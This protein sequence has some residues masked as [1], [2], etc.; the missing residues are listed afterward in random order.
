MQE[1]AYRLSSRPMPSVFLRLG[2][3][4]VLGLA[5]CQGHSDPPPAAAP[6]NSQRPARPEPPPLAPQPLGRSGYTVALP[7]DY[8]LKPTDGP[9]FQVYYFAPADTL[10]AHHFTGGLYF[11]SQPQGPDS[12][13]GCQVRQQPATLLGRPATWH[14]TRCAS[15]YAVYAVF[16]SRSGR[17][18]D[19]QINAFGEARSAAELRQLLAVFATLRRE[20]GQ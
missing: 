9:D 17:G 6:P 15:G 10:A 7:A 3:A 16:D 19:A 12:T 14:I 18:W 1:R 2:S 11:G 8:A 5:A 4:V 13:A 20:A